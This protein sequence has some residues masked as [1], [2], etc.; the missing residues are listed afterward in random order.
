MDAKHKLL[1]IAVVLFIFHQGS[2]AALGQTANPSTPLTEEQNGWLAHANRHEKHGWIYLHIEG[3]PRERGFQHGY[4]LAAEIRESLR[5][6]NVVWQHHSGMDWPWLVKKAKTIFDPKVDPENRAEIDG[7]VEGL[8]AAGVSSSREELITL[9]GIIELSDY[10]WPKEKEKMDK[11]SKESA[12]EACSAFIAT[13]SMTNDGGVV[14]GHNTMGGFVD[15]DC[16]IILDIQPAKG[17]RIL[18]QASPG[19]IHSGTDFF[20]TDAGLV[21]AET[22]IS[23]FKGFD[24][25]GIPEFV[26]MRR[27][28]QDASSHR[29]VVRDHEKATTTAATPT[30]GCWATSTRRRS[31]GSNW[32]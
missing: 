19:W 9:N 8:R 30:P 1:K 12:R 22:T 11:D 32:G 25:K 3:Q 21:G 14:L 24:D 15:A 28:T 2:F 16:K 29:R 5:A 20:I 23:G 26:R 10:W 18:M 17:H 13:G 7:M 4:L 27:A 6:S 31:P